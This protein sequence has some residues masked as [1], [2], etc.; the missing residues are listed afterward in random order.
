MFSHHSRP[1]SRYFAM[2]GKYA[3]HGP[4]DAICPPVTYAVSGAI[5]RPK[6]AGIAARTPSMRRIKLVC[7]VDG[8][9]IEVPATRPDSISIS[10][11]SKLWLFKIGTM[12]AMN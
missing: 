11:P 1:L 9:V 8:E 6:L 5:V 3:P 7:D 10:M 2:I 4:P 12:V